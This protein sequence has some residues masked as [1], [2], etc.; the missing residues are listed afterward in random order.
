MEAEDVYVWGGEV[1]ISGSDVTIQYEQQTEYSDNELLFQINENITQG[2][3]LLVGLFG[4]I[5]GFMA[6]KEFFKIWLH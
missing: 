2:F 3:S 6:A 5:L 4:M 1:T